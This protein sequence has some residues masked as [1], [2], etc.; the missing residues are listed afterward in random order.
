MY[1]IPL[2]R[3]TVSTGRAY[4]ISKLVEETRNHLTESRSQD[5]VIKAF[6]PADDSVTAVRDWISSVLGE[7]KQ[8]THTDNKAWL[9]FDA[10]TA[11][12]ETLL[13]TQY[14]EHHD[15]AGG[16]VKVTCVSFD[17]LL[18][19]GATVRTTLLAKM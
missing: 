13:H 15:E 10:S 7:K 9:A 19:I 6:Q 16:R 17:I 12:L 11:E 3:A 4:D 14:H 2:V 8:I 1:R 18:S 5:D